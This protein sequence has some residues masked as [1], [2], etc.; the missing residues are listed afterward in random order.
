MTTQIKE[1]NEPLTMEH[2]NLAI[3]SAKRN[4]GKSHLMNE[5]DDI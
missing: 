5:M 2:P 3:F 4:S 1:F